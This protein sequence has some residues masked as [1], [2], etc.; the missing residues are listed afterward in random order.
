M[1][2][3]WSQALATIVVGSISMPTDSSRGSS[4]TAYSAS[5]AQRSEPKPCSSL[6][7]RSV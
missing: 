3:I 5:I 7:P 6:M 2:A 1:R 4:F